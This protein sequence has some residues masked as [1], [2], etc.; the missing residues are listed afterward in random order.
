MEYPKIYWGLSVLMT[1]F[2]VVLVIFFLYYGHQD[3]DKNCSTE[4]KNCGLEVNGQFIAIVIAVVAIL[5]IG[6][7]IL[8]T[9]VYALEG[10]YYK[11]DYSS[12]NT[13][14]RQRT[15]SGAQERYSDV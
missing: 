12:E 10:F 6:F 1:V 13:N 4:N 11:V 3:K 9:L 15:L 2:Y 14:Q 8:P 7:C 5:L